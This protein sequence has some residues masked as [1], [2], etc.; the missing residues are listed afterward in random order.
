MFY[1]EGKNMKILKSKLLE[2]L[3]KNFLVTYFQKLLE[4]LKKEYLRELDTNYRY[5]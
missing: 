5:I 2:K 3:T 4:H 1:R